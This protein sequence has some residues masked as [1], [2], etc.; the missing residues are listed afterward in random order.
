[1]T[2]RLTLVILGTVAATLLFAGFGTLALARLG[3]RDQTTRDLRSQATDIAASIKNLDDQKQIGILNQVRKSL[4]LEGISIV[5]Y[6][7]GG[8]GSRAGC[9]WMTGRCSAG[10]CSC[11][12]PGSRGSSCRRSVGSARG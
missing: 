5:R 9:R 6:G 2:R 3:A 8:R 11:F 4:N 12:T 7:P 10:S 1:M